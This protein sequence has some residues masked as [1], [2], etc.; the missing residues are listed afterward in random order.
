[1]MESGTPITDDHVDDWVDKEIQKCINLSNP[2]SFILYAGAG[3]GKT[4]SLVKLLSDIPTTIRK[5]MT[6][7]GRQ[8]AVITYTNA[9]SEEIQ[10]RVKFDPL[11]HISTIHSFAWSVIEGYSTDIRE[12]LRV[13]LN[14]DIL[15]LN[16]K[17][18]K[19]RKVTARENYIRKLDK[20]KERLSIIDVA[21][22]FI[23]SPTG[24]NTAL[25]SLNHSE[26]IK[27]CASF[28]N[29]NPVFCQ[30]LIG[31]FPIILV[32]E[33]QDTAKILME[34]FLLLQKNHQDLMILGL[35]GDMMQRI[36]MDGLP[37]LDSKIP[38]DWIKLDKKMN[39]RSKERIIR[40]INNIRKQGD[41]K[42]QD[43]RA[44]KRGGV[45]HAF[46]VKNDYLTIHE[47]EDL[48]TDK[49]ISITLD[50]GWGSDLETTRR[51]ILE[52]R[53]AADRL[54]FLTIFDTINKVGAYKDGI[55]DGT[56]KELLFFIDQVIPLLEIA[57]TNNIYNICQLLDKYSDRYAEL[58]L[59]EVTTIK[60]RMDDFISIVMDINN[61]VV[62]ED[63]HVC[64][65]SL[66]KYIKNNQILTLPEDL[67]NTLTEIDS[68]EK[69]DIRY[70]VWT[71]IF[72]CN[73]D[74]LKR[75][76]DYYAD[77]SGY[78]TH[79]GVKGL[80]YKHVMGI[81]SDNEAAGNSFSYE[82]L[83]GVKDLT[84]TDRKNIA[85]G[86]DSSID[87][88]NRLLY[89]VASRAEESLALILYTAKTDELKEFLIEHNFFDKA[90]ITVYP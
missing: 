38:T 49:M 47:V 88:T 58:T 51:L 53:M 31:R 40:L 2:K 22:S 39:H 52:H 72:D 16:K 64:L 23:Y 14:E 28:I 61:Q 56:L 17:I 34:A 76:I 48:V 85:D 7:C 12:W 42:R 37:Q 6:G 10:R 86:K 8:V 19:S 9:A 20:K 87:R 79:Q 80:E 5:E 83:F 89:V 27:I 50:D 32:D 3:S 29:E 78:A 4:R 82:K 69:S 73:L 13:K 44:D 55:K 35:F 15:E 57:N 21:Q 90:E 25:N 68:N 74:E 46:V 70:E 67:E 63:D 24:D 45:V 43:N 41:D 77:A 36:Y 54:G 11:Y 65:L 60:Q 30:I 71:K 59:G 18:D 84:E 62:N 1:M 33:S 66:I 26:V 81:I 75:M